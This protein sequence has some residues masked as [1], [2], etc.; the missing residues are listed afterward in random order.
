[1]I[2]GVAAAGELSSRERGDHGRGGRRLMD[3]VHVIADRGRKAQRRR[4]LDWKFN[5]PSSIPG[6]PI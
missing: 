2:M 5:Y 1:M 3:S 4:A 6:P